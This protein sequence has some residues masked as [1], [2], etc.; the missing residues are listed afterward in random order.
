VPPG[1]E[2]ELRQLH[3]WLAQ[4]QRGERCVGFVAGEAGI[5]KTT[6]VDA[7]LAQVAATG[8]R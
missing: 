5:G 4:A 2:A 8:T 1:R 3:A 7:F 6:L